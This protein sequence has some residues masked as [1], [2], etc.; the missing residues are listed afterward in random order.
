[1]IRLSGIFKVGLTF[2]AGMI[3]AATL[4]VIVEGQS[5]LDLTILPLDHSAI[6]YAQTPGD[7]PVA[8]LDQ[9]LAS[10]KI[11]LDFRSPKL[12]Y[13]PSILKNLGVDVDSQL[14]VFS[15]TSFQATK[16]SPREPRAL[17]FD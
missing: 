14:L 2:G 8:R 10:G 9:K 1:M 6:Q 13:L 11:K 17:F 16:I 3:L 7:D 12:G 5:P 15:K 4:T